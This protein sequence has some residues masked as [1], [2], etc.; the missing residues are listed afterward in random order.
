MQAPQYKKDIKIFEWVQR[1]ATKMVRGLDGMTFEEH[2]RILV[3]FSLEVW[4]LRGDLLV[5]YNFLVKGGVER[6]SLTSSLWRPMIGYD[7]MT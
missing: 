1:R 5:A 2:L 6:E 7:E 3:F 4:S